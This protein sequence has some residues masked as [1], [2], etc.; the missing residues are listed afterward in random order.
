MLSCD[1]WGAGEEGS[2]RR[3]EVLTGPLRE[4]SGDDGI[5]MEG[6]Y[7]LSTDKSVIISDNYPIK[8]HLQ[9][10]FVCV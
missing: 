7:F 3:E 10:V 2:G 6:N 9:Q 1:T 4:V 8:Y 5:W